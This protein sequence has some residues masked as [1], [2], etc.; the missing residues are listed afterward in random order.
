MRRS[1]YAAAAAAAA[2][3]VAQPC[4]A[5]GAFQGDGASE[6]RSGA[7]AGV[8]LRLPLGEGNPERPSARLQ[9][10]TSHEYRNAAGATVRTIRPDGVELGLRERGAVSWRIGGQDIGRRDERLGINGSTKTLLT[11]GVIIVAVVVLIPVL[12]ADELPVP[13]FNDQD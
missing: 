9:L 7:F 8:R 6:R 11:I 4:F 5:A 3:L 13:D 10:T 1:K 12:T 2:M